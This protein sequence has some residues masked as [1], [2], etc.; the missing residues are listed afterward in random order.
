MTAL[1]PWPASLGA[2]LASVLFPDGPTRSAPLRP[3]LLQLETRARPLSSSPRPLPCVLVCPAHLQNQAGLPR[4]RKHIH[5]SSTSPEN[6]VT[7]LDPPIPAVFCRPHRRN[8]CRRPL[9]RHG[10]AAA[11]VFRSNRD[12]RRPL[13]VDRALDRLERPFLPRPIRPL[14]LSTMWAKPLW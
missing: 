6:V 13:P 7:H 1:S 12:Q 9:H 3:R 11:S 14:F 2:Q 5:R 8:S 10:C 4:P